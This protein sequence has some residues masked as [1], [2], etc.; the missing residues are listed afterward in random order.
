MNPNRWRRALIG[1]R[2]GLARSL[3]LPDKSGLPPRA[4]GAPNHLV[5]K[6][7]KPKRPRWVAYVMR[8]K[9]AER[10]GEVEA[11]TE[12]EAWSMACEEFGITQ[13][14]QKRRVFV[15]RAPD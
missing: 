10:L 3:C 15:R 14:W 12:A 5:P 8:G 13:D 9:R 11:D 4:S 7:P 2:R 6:R 1:A